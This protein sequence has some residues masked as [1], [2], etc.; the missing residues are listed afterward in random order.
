MAGPTTCPSEIRLDLVERAGSPTGPA[1]RGPEPPCRC[2][3][4][5]D[6]ARARMSFLS[7]RPV[8][9]GTVRQPILTSWTRSRLGQVPIDHLAPPFD[10]DR[11][12]G[13]STLLR[14]AM[15]VLRSLSDQLGNEPV[16][17]ILCDSEGLVVHR[18]TGDP[19]L[20]RRLDH[21][22][23][24][25]GFNYA[26]RYV[27]TNGIGTALEGRGPAVVLGEEHYC[28]QLTR[29]A[30][31][32]API[33]HPVSGKVLGVINLTCW[34]RDASTT[35]GVT[36]PAIAQQIEESLRQQVGSRDQ[37]FLQ[38]YLEASW[39]SRG[40]VIALS[41]DLLLLNDRARHW[42]SGE[43]Q[44]ALL[45][46]GTDALHEG[47]RRNLVIDLPSGFRAQIR[48]RPSHAKKSSGV[49]LIQ[50]A[51]R[52]VHQPVCAPAGTPPHP[53]VGA[54]PVWTAARQLV[55]QHFQNREWLIL[56]GEAGSGKTT[57]ARATHEC[58]T[59]AARLRILDCADHGPA[60]DADGGAEWARTI[61]DELAI[62]GS[63][64]LSHVDRLPA[65]G[66]DRLAAVLANHETT[67][68]EKPWVAATVT[69]GAQPPDLADLFAHFPITVEV[70]ALRHRIDDL[71]ALVPHLLAR[72]PYGSELSV[73]PDAMR[74]LMRNRWPG[75]VAQLDKVLRTIVKKRRGGTIGVRDLPAECYTM[76]R[77]Q[78]TPLEAVECD[79]IVAALLAAGGNKRE[80]AERIGMSRATIFR[81]IR[82][83]G[84]VIPRLTDR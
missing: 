7:D 57:L 84:I 80:A 75:N 36:I 38:E 28:E 70:P 77:R 26:E 20:V 82:A 52:H 65:D 34:H 23:L 18:D 22:S 32:G 40:A 67:T 21:V 56:E 73:S 2:T 45:V 54:A 66:L 35:L 64:I 47:G 29:L 79:T 31:A 14:A 72:I 8:A 25:P 10:D 63:L 4:A 62:G 76:S 48:C 53:A 68:A 16:S 17:V 42:F 46:H 5:Q 19:E 51:A 55:D 49:L 12:D 11:L 59:P 74:V 39:R 30:C 50:P 3:G 37:A 13:E 81:K 1:A 69:T 27:G 71:P 43:D 58:R 9:P 6:V 41:E 83:Y 44:S 60:P 33:R 15:P 61:A 78:L 24:R